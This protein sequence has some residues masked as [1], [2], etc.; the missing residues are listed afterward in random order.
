MRET[1]PYQLIFMIWAST[2]HYADFQAQV[3]AILNK[4]EFDSD[5]LQET[6]SFIS[7]MILRGCGLS[8]KDNKP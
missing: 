8:V 6:A 2:Q 7:G 3:L 4:A 1:D 5:L